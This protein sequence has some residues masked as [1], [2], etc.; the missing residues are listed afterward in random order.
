M[1]VL[2]LACSVPTDVRHGPDAARSVTAPTTL[3]EPPQHRPPPE[4]ARTLAPSPATLA[5]ALA[6]AGVEVALADLVPR[7][8]YRMDDPDPQLA[9]LRTGVILCDTALTVTTANDHDLGERLRLLQVGLGAMDADATLRAKV[10]DLAKRSQAGPLDRAALLGEVDAL[11]A[12][13]A[14]SNGRAPGTRRESLLH[15]G[16]WVALSNL[17][18]TAV[19]RSGKIEVADAL[20]HQSDAA[21]WFLG[22]ARSAAVGLGEE[23]VVR[24]LE[25]HLVTLRDVAAKDHLGRAEVQAIEEHTAAILNLL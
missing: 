22:E 25:G 4:A 12:L 24:A 20:F 23:A 7:R 9:A 19:L 2:L 5:R 11:A 8:L 1:L 6:D 21:S 17:A 13:T 3:A 16:E 14:E 18:A 10:D 15:A